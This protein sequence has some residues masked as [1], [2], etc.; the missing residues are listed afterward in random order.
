MLL[1]QRLR[2]DVGADWLIWV[3]LPVALAAGLLLGMSGS[4]TLVALAVGGLA[5][6]YLLAIDQRALAAVIIVGVGLLL[7]YTQALPLPF[8]F[9]TIATLLALFFLVAWFLM[10]SAE[11][12]WVRVPHLGWWICLLVLAFLP[13]LRGGVAQ[14]GRY[15]V[16]VLFNALLLYIVGVQVARSL[17]HVRWLFSLLSGFAALVAIHSFLQSRTGNVLLPGHYWDSY[18][19]SVNYFTLIGSTHIRAGSFFINPDSDGAFLALMFFIPVSLLLE[20]PSRR[21]KV[22]YGVEAALILLGLF[23]TYSLASIATV[24]AGGIVFLFLVGR[25]RYRFYALGFIGMLIV[26]ILVAFPSLLRSLYNH[27]TAPGELTLRLGAWETAI[28]VILAHPLTGLGLSFYTYRTGAELYRVPLQTSTLAH[29][30]NSFLE[31]AALGG[32]PVL[33]IFLVIFGKAWW[34]AFRNYR[35]G[36]KAQHTLL[37]GGMTALIVITMNSFATNAW[38]LPPLVILDWLILG[39]LCSPALLQPLRARSRSEKGFSNREQEAG[40]IITA[41]GGAQA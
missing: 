40:E 11:R 26:G 29:P 37:G 7:D 38:T 39:A 8:F 41:S 5:L 27:L 28:R 1:L 6:A 18:L 19:V 33:L 10:Q 23:F 22:L 3:S 36:G 24:C 14:G 34:V 31:L 17:A 15:Y 16:T 35:G 20:A 9:P 2:P 21:L 32:I 4:F 12:S 13:A 25:G 30:H